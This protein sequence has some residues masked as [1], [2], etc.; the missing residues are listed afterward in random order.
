MRALILGIGDA[1]TS[2]GFGTSAL[3]EGPE[4]YFLLDC[5]DLIHRAIREACATSGWMVDHNQ[6]PDV[7]ITHLHGDHV[8]GLESYG[9]ARL[10]ARLRGQSKELPRVHTH[11]AAAARLWERLAPAMDPPLTRGGRT[12]VL[13]DFFDV[14]TVE[15]GKPARIAGLTVECRYTIH[16]VPTIGLKI[17]DGARTLGWSGDT[18]FEQAHIDWLSDADVI[19]HEA[20]LG[21]AHTQIEL[22]NALPAA[23]RRKMR[24]THVIDEYD[25]S[26]SD[27][28]P[29]Q[30]GEVIEF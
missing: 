9:W 8:N 11:P 20:N 12:S 1:F 2:R 14:R 17:S 23:V 24:I 4:G 15:P 3:I 16:P 6:I 18:C 5:P 29:L 27:I 10:V 22:L 28:Q 19:V 26:S 30:E 21:P 13:S 7:L 25:R